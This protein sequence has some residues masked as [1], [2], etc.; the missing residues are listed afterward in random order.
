MSLINTGKDE[1]SAAG[2]VLHDKKGADHAR[3]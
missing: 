1:Q 2:Q 3:G